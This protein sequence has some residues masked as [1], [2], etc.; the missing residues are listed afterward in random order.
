[1]E[2]R[3]TIELIIGKFG[4]TG[5]IVEF[6]KALDV[7]V[8]GEHPT[9]RSGRIGTIMRDTGTVPEM[10]NADG[11][12]IGVGKNDVFAGFLSKDAGRDISRVIRS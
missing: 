8:L 4:D 10:L 11:L 12:D 5:E 9:K 7:F 3:A 1:M 2:I 6:K